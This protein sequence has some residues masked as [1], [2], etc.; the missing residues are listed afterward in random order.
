VVSILV[1]I[2]LPDFSDTTTIGILTAVG[3][4]LAAIAAI[5]G[6]VSVQQ[7]SRAW[8]ASSRPL[9]QMLVSRH[10][11]TGICTITL[12]N[13]GG[14]TAL[15]TTILFVSGSS[16]ARGTVGILGPGRQRVLNTDPMPDVTSNPA[17]GLASCFEDDERS[18]AQTYFLNNTRRLY[19]KRLWRT[20]PSDD[21]MFA[22]EYPDVPLDGLEEVAVHTPM[23]AQP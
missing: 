6:V 16:V 20:V 17:G 19:R 10:P 9:L 21:E 8:R 22:E 11:T 5:T 2:A 12:L 23:L 18:V 1:S 15:G 4:A 3:V 13:S 7:G 14:G